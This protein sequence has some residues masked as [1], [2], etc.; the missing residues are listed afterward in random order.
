MEDGRWVVGF[1]SNNGHASILKA[2][3]MT[4]YHGMVVLEFGA[5]QSCCFSDSFQA[6]SLIDEAPGTFHPYV[7]VFS[8]IL[9]L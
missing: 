9:N 7:V 3:L 6:V 8:A 4:I 1:S 5:T 2:E